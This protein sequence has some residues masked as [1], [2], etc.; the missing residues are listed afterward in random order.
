MLKPQKALHLYLDE[1]KAN[2]KH[3]GET[4]VVMEKF[5]GWYMYIDCINGKWQDITSRNL[6]VISSMSEYTKLLKKYLPV[7]K[8]D[9]RL[10]FEGIVYDQRRYP[11]EFKTVN[12]WFNRKAPIHEQVTLKCHDLVIFGEESTPFC[13]RY[14]NLKA[15]FRAFKKGSEWLQCLDL[16]KWLDCSSTPQEWYDI[17]EEV[18]TQYLNNGEGV[19]LK[20]VNAPYSYGKKNADVLKIKCEKAF[21]L[22]VTAIEEGEGKYKGTLGKL[23]VKDANGIINKVSGMSDKQRDLWFETPSLIVG[24]IV[25]VACMKVLSNKSLREGRFKAVRFDKDEVD[26]L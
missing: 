17:Y 15:M 1:D 18:T 23:V 7:P 24:S 8:K 13:L 22:L 19:I 20:R 14:S 21:E 12:G 5:D 11:I 25:E 10:I 16:V 4:Y 3:A 26:A 9:A 2:P 6:N